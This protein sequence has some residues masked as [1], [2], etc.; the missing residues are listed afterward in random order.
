MMSLTI[1]FIVYTYGVV[2]KRLN[3]F[4]SLFSVPE[5]REVTKWLS[6]CGCLLGPWF[7]FI[8]FGV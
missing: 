6:K 3:V 2:L 5:S 8:R 4:V 1:T 7:A